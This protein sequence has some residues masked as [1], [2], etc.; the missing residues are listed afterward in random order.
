MIKDH[1]VLGQSIDIRALDVILPVATQFG[2]QIIHDQKEDIGW[3]LSG[4]GLCV[5]R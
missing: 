3:P 1:A 4:A 5:K 2:S